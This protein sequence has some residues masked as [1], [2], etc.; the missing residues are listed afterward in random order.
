MLAVW[1]YNRLLKFVART[2]PDF[3]PYNIVSDLNTVNNQ[4]FEGNRFNFAIGIFSP[5][6]GKYDAIE[7]EFGRFELFEIAVDGGKFLRSPGVV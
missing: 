4:T 7:P 3:I 1:V 5:R 2:D 6:T